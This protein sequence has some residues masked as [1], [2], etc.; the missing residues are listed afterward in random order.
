MVLP[1]TGGTSGK[2]APT[3]GWCMPVLVLRYQCSFDCGMR[4]REK[5]GIFRGA[6]A[7]IWSVGVCNCVGGVV[8]S[9]R[10]CLRV[11]DVAFGSLLVYSGPMLE[12]KGLQVAPM[13]MCQG[14]DL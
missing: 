11:V 13:L 14:V 5:V 9:V 6:L 3:D 4:L 8:V 2:A 1:S 10:S 7:G 12:Q